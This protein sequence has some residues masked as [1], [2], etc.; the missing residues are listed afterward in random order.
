[1]LPT[2]LPAFNR[3]RWLIFSLLCTA[4]VLAFFHRVAPTVLAEELALS[5][6]ASAVALGSIAAMYFHIYAAM[7]IPAGIIADRVGTRTTV[8]LSVGVG[9]IG[10]IVFGLAPDVFTAS[11]GRFII[12]FGVSFAFVGTLRAVGFWYRPEQYA[13]V[14]GWVILVGN[15]GAILAGTPLALLLE[16][17]TW[18]TAFVWVG[19]F[20]LGL[21]AAILLFVRDKPDQAGFPTQGF[22]HPQHD[23]ISFWQGLGICLRHPSIWLCFLAGFALVGSFFGFA[24][25]WAVPF[26]VHEV[27]L[28]PREAADCL[29]LAMLLLAFTPAFIGWFSDRLARRKQIIVWS[30]FIGTATWAVLGFVPNLGFWGA[31]LTVTLGGA[32]CC[33]MVVIYATAKDLAPHSAA[34]FAVALVNTGLFTGAALLQIWLGWLLSLNG[35]K[36]DGD[37]PPDFHWA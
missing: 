33:G 32:A 2:H 24:G 1:M 10:S 6:N 34:G 36:P 28:T 8:G 14:S 19:L 31:C 35:Y 16:L 11:L 27:K 13:Q 18:R 17:I 12:G 20:S 22:E 4:F 7:Q 29:T 21:A 23:E 25:I 26:L 37:I 15:L 3:R 5:L 30:C 9:G